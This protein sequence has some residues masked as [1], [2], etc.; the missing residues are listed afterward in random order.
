MRKKYRDL[1]EDSNFLQ[2]YCVSS[3]DYNSHIGGYDE[4]T[5]PLSLAVTGIPELRLGI[6]KLPA[7]SKLDVL[8]LHCQGMVPT[9][10]GSLEAWALKSAT[11]RYAEIREIVAKPHQV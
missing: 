7:Q 1:A 9:V 2:V 4:D 6:L 5:I 11:K 8:K 10:V 3:L